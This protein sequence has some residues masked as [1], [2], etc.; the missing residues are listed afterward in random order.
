MVGIGSWYHTSSYLLM[1]LFHNESVI[2]VHITVFGMYML[3]KTKYQT[4]IQKPQESDKH[5]ST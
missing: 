2:N 5:V 4:S 3:L 1:F